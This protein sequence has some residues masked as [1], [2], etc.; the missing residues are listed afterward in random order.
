MKKLAPSILAAD[1]TKLGEEVRKIDKLGADYIHI[2]VMDGAYVPSIS[3]GVPVIKAIRQ[4]TS[5]VFDVHLMVEE[6]IRYIEDFVEAGAD[7]ITVHAEACKHLHRTISKIKKYGIKAGVSLNP[8]TPLCTLEYV[9]EEL[10]MVLIMSVEPG[11]GGQEFIPS[12]LNKIKALRAMIIA[13]DLSIP[14]E[15]DGGIHLENVGEI[16]RAGGD[17]IV[18]GTSVFS[19]DIVRNMEIFKEVLQNADEGN[20]DW[21]V[22]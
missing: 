4:E 13:K 12:T 8:A 2:D 3:F 16:I 1:F 21:K 18:A 19:G 22:R 10:D 20:E 17:I 14:I 11:F 6:P 15:V 5:L 9:L 7:I